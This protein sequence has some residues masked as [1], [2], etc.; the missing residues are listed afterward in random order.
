MAQTSSTI[1][2]IFDGVERGVVAAAAKSAAAIKSL[3]DDNSK[4]SKS[5]DKAGKGLFAVGKGMAV[6]GAA[7]GAIQVI[8]GV[9]GALEQLAPA[10]L[11]LPGALLAGG[12]AMGTFKLATAGMGDALKAGLSGDMK[13]FAEATKGMAPE[14]QA[15]AKAVTAFKPQIDGLK[16]VVQG[17]FW[18]GFADGIKEVGNNLLPTVSE[19]LG[20]IAGSLN[21]AAMG[22]LDVMKTRFFRGDVDKILTNTTKTISNMAPAVGD[23]LTGFV[24]LGAVGSQYLP[25]LGT[26]VSGVTL[27]FRNWVQANN[28]AGGKIE[29]LIDGALQGFK[30]L[31]GIVKNVGSILGSV[32][33]GLGGQISSPLAR[34]RELTGQVAAFLKTAA[35]QDGLRALGETLQVVGHVVGDVVMTA[36]KELA[37]TLVS[38]APVAQEVARTLGDLLVGALETLGPIIRGIADLFAAFP[39]SA[40]LATVAIV[41]FVATVKAIKM[42]NAVTEFLGL[43]DSIFQ[44]GSKAEGAGGKVEGFGKKLGGLKGIGAGLALGAAVVV[45]DQINERSEQG[46]LS[47]WNGELHDMQRILTGDWGDPFADISKQLDEVGA[48]WKAGQ[49]P[50]QQ[51]A[52]AVGQAATTAGTAIQNFFR[53][54]VGLPPLPPIN[55]DVD[56]STGE[57]RVKEFVGG[58][59]R[60]RGTVQVDGDVNPATGKVRQT[61]TFANGSK[62]TITI[63]GN[64]IPSD[65]K[66]TGAVQF[67]NGSKGTITVDGNQTPANGKIN[68]TVTY[69]NG[70]TGTIQ[71]NANTGGAQGVIDSFIQRNDGRQIRIFTSVLGSGGIASAGRLASGGPVVGP[72]TG[73]SDT[74]GL[75][76]LSSGEY[77][78]TARQVDNAGGPAAF[79]QLMNALD[80]GRPAGLAGGGSPMRASARAAMRTPTPAALAGAGVVRVELVAGPGG[81]A[82]FMAAFQKAVRVGA[83][84][85]KVA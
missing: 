38:L 41:G 36:L 66:V 37:P 8:G 18:Q 6:L 49:A 47:G 12:A 21:E 63:D 13:K 1:K 2:L 64:R 82:L 51:W 79:G 10:A 16:K 69:A 28:E 70:R 77:V 7:N 35:A 71:I 4:L 44:L 83:I 62:G 24:G 78:A 55:L 75:F 32:F 80:R 45:M 30:D 14:M 29:Q 73:T 84:Q 25:R 85:L 26:A 57:A 68:A 74:A 39:G 56:P 81:D 3:D 54:L 19:G 65:G 27:K 33:T 53:G 72:G 76:A 11:L 20:A 9:A 67:A 22:A 52:L 40:S 61:V 34:I 31:G 42:A 48:K 23:V 15:A 60:Q 58:V 17:N 5:A 59:S 50:V 43:G 46:N